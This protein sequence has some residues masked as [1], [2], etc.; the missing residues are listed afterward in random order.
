MKMWDAIRS[1]FYDPDFYRRIRVE[2]LNFGIK[3]AALLG[4]IGIGISL[5]LATP[6]LVSFAHSNLPQALESAYPNDLVVTIDNGKMSI[7]QPQPYYVKNTLPYFS[8]QDAPENLVVFDG[9]DKLEPDLNKNSTI[10]LA[11]ETYLIAEG[12]HNEQQ[13][14]PLSRLGTTTITIDKSK[15]VATI[16]TVKPYFVP[17]VYVGG[18][19]LFVLFVLGGTF[20]WLLFHMVYLLIPALLIFLFSLM[21]ENTFTFMESYRTA[22]FA[23]IPVAIVFYLLFSMIL[24]S[25]APEFTYTL[26]VLVVALVNIVE[27]K[28]KV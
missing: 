5:L 12:Q 10:V 20:F 15:V 8:G 14:F 28:F 7:N 21:R 11:K 25:P 2:S 27:R 18:A 23:S 6:A 19:F 1:C 22:F 26:F 4:A 13:I 24:H 9:T 16:D 3:V 17:V